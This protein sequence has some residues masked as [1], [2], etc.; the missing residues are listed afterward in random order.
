MEKF[1]QTLAWIIIIS[2]GLFISVHIP[3]ALFVMI[4]VGILL[5]LFK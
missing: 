3:E 5:V 4:I 2:I 1:K